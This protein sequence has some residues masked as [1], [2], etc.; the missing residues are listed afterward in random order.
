MINIE[1]FKNNKWHENIFLIIYYFSWVLYILSL[2]GI[3][4]F[5]INFFNDIQQFIRIYISLFLII[6][7]NPFTNQ[8]KF[9]NFD[10]NIVFQAGVFILSTTL[11]NQLVKSVF[12]NIIT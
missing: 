8:K 12:N 1:I 11:L 6:K 5:G 9:N 7:F 2:L 10:K 3:S 4:F